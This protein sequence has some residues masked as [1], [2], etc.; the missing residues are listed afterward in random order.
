MLLL[1]KMTRAFLRDESG[2]SMTEYV[3]LLFMVVMAVKMAGGQ[4]GPRLK[5]I[6][7]A[8]FTRAED[9]VNSGG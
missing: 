9:E 2:Q 4:I 1:K 6:I 8:A 7:D 3:L 5:G